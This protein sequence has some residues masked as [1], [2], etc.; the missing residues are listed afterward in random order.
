MMAEVR[1]GF[2]LVTTLP[3]GEAVVG[4]TIFKDRLYVA[5]TTGVFRLKNNKLEPLRI[6]LPPTEQ[7]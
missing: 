4:M 7:K 1:T 3:V 6:L 5:T 2:T